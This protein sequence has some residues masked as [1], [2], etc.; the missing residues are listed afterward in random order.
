MV[1][2]IS[3]VLY[4]CELLYFVYGMFIFSGLFFVLFTP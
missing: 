3:I 4:V 1:C 2:C